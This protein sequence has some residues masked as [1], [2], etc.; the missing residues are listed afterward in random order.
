MEYALH[1]NCKVAASSTNVDMDKVIPDGTPTGYAYEVLG[2]HE[3]TH[4]GKKEKLVKLCNPWE[5]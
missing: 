5:E 1:L 2:F 4:D 3:V